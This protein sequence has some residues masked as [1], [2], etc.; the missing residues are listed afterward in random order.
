MASNGDARQVSQRITFHWWNGA[1]PS[2]HSMHHVVIAPK[3]NPLKVMVV[4][5][6]IRQDHVGEAGA[7][8]VG[9]TDC[10]PWDAN[11]FH[12]ENAL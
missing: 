11:I 4:I 7:P 8:S 6:I 3:E 9:V 2:S 1:F 5:I 10:L 12:V